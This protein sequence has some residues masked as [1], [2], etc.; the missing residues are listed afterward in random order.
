VFDA[1]VDGKRTRMLAAV[2]PRQ[3]L[4]YPA[5]VGRNGSG[6]HV[7]W[8]VQVMDSPGNDKKDTS[9]QRSHVPSKDCNK[10]TSEILDVLTSQG[11]DCEAEEPGS[12]VL[13]ES[14]MTEET[15]GEP[16]DL[17][18]LTTAQVL[19]VQTR[20]QRKRQEQQLQADAAATTAS[21]AVIHNLV[22]T[23]QAGGSSPVD[24]NGGAT[25]SGGS[26]PADRPG[27]EFTL[28]ED[29]DSED[30]TSSVATMV[31]DVVT[32]VDDVACGEEE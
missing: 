15:S 13:E 12:Q 11:G 19:A 25:S 8:D 23:P 18:H 16:L 28:A 17:D 21:G 14:A 26:L 2:A 24:Q 29:T 27:R 22:D 3:E 4:P 6:L 30:E 32:L 10:P 9:I 20:A 31:E 5:I 7:Q 1:E